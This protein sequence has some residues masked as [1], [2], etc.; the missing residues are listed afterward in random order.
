MRVLDLEMKSEMKKIFN[1]ILEVIEKRVNKLEDRLI[2]KIKSEEQKEKKR[3]KKNKKSF[4]D[5]QSNIKGSNICGI[6][7]SEG[8]Q[9]ESATEKNMYIFREIMVKNVNLEI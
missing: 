5:L 8:D 3:Q 2:E 4:S 6:G 1:S 9:I 7:G